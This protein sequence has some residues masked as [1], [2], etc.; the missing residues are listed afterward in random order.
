MVRRVT[1]AALGVLALGCASCGTSPSERDASRSVERFYSALGARDGA[2]ACRQLSPDAASALETSEGK[3]CERA[4]LSLT[5][6]QS[7]VRG[8]S[9]WVTS[10]QVTLRSG[11][12]AFL[13]QVGDRWVIG[14]AG[15]RPRPG[16]PYD[17]E[18]EG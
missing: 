14:A 3:P 8:A 9:V 7:P 15:C 12:A 6:R 4:V 16:Q 2:A 10:A 1:A 13:D 5:L 11:T 17:C 18:L